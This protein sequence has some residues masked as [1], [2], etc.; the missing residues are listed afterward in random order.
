MI[1]VTAI[2]L[3]SAEMKG[4]GPMSVVSV[5]ENTMVNGRITDMGKNNV[6]GTPG[7]MWKRLRK[8]I[9]QNRASYIMLA[10]FFILF[11]YFTLIPIISAFYLSFTYFNMLETPKFIGW[12]NY[13]RLF[14]DDDVFLIAIRNTIIMAFITGPISYFACLLFAWLINELPRTLKTIMTFVFYAPSISGN[15]FVIWIYIFSGDAYGLVNNLLTRLGILNDAIQWLTNPRYALFILII[16]QL[17][18]SLGAS[19]LSFI[20]GLQ[21]INPELYE[22]GAIDGIRNRW[23]ELFRIT[24]PSMGPQLMFGAVMQIA[25]SFSVGYISIMLTGFPSTDY[26]THTIITHVY[27][28]GNLRFEMGYASAVSVVLFILILAS[29]MLIRKIISTFASQDV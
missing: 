13:I 3:T 9:R 14:L 21:N 27:D 4:C 17:W 24:L 6:S 16:I 15:M 26:S 23:Q 1:Q 18:L 8:M 28:Y 5:K 19:F 10:P 12:N 22:A 11:A 25:S 20:A 29:N 2:V 7:M